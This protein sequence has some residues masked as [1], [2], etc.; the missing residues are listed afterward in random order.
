MRQDNDP[1]RAKG[2]REMQ[3]HP[4]IGPA[5]DRARSLRVETASRSRFECVEA[6]LR[7]PTQHFFSRLIA[8]ARPR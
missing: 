1:V 5:R 4:T 6:D 3:D 8:R 7:R 2:A